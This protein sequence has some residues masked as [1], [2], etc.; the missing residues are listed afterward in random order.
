MCT[1]TFLPQSEEAFILTSNRDEAPARKTLPPA[2][3]TESGVELLYPKDAVAGGTWIGSSEKKRVVSI[4]NGGFIAHKRKKSYRKS[5]GLV[6]KDLLIADDV[7]VEIN[8]YNFE[9]IEPFTVIIVDWNQKLRLFQL[10]WDGKKTHFSL[11]KIQPAIWSSSPLYPS[12]L[13]AR[14]EQ[15]FLKFLDQYPEPG[16]KQILQFHKNGGEGDPFSNLVMDRGFVKTKSITQVIKNNNGI[17]MQYID[18]ETNEM[19]IMPE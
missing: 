8:N 2:V 9:N 1:I 6:V 7:V 18:L 19:V 5:R 16:L 3:Y 4:M 15:W 13:K 14:R 17:E 12:A 10:V 11:Q